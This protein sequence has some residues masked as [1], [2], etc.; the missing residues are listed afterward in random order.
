MNLFSQSAR[1]GKKII[2]IILCKTSQLKIKIKIRKMKKIF[3][4]IKNIDIL[5]VFDISSF[6]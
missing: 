4:I 3:F 2:Y 6:L 1:D 5:C